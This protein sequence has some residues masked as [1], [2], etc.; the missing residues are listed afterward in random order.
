MDEKISAGLFFSLLLLVFAFSTVES[1]FAPQ[2][3]PPSNYSPFN[4][5][6]FISGNVSDARDGTSANDYNITIY[7][8][9][10]PDN[11]LS[12]Y[13]GPN[14]A[15]G[16]NNIFLIDCQQLNPKCKVGDIITARVY[17]NGS[18]YI[19]CP[20]NVTVTGGASDKAPNMTLT[21]DFDSDG[22]GNICD[23]I[24]STSFKIVR[25]FHT[26]GNLSDLF[27]SD[28]SYLSVR[29]GLTLFLGEPP[30]QIELI[31]EAP[32]NSVSEF[33]FSV[34]SSMNTPGVEQRIELFNYVTGAYERVDTKQAT[35]SD[36]VVEIVIS[37][38]PDRFIN[39]DREMKA[40][41]I[42]KATG[43]TLVWPWSTRIDHVFWI[44]E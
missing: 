37:S 16:V 13:I 15:S 1:I 44:L 21:K 19:T 18:H 14:G 7:I 33:K 12:D 10:T 42:F 5:A 25:G 27:S 36:S 22:L 11:N 6:H 41:I 26:S 2:N 34:E 23:P 38:N 35:T 32:T 43:L 3:S 40:K 29:A 39:S 8:S 31:T 9:G 4:F 20:V 30:I 28:D 17:D 24:L